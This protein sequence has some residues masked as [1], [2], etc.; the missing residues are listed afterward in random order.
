MVPCV[1]DGSPSPY[2]STSVAGLGGLDAGPSECGQV[3]P[4]FPLHLRPRG[5]MGL[6]CTELLSNQ[7]DIALPGWYEIP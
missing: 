6:V 5:P 3:R 4:P 1:W 2:S 7:Q